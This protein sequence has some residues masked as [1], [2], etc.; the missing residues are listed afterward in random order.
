MKKSIA[1]G[2]KRGSVGILILKA[3]SSGDKYGYEILKEVEE[4]SG[5]EYFLKQPSLYSSL[6]RMAAN[7]LITSYWED[8]DIGG[9]R[10]YYNL[11]EAGKQKLENSNFQWP[12]SKGFVKDMFAD[13]TPTTP[14]VSEEPK[15]EIVAEKSSIDIVKEEVAKIEAEA[16][17]TVEEVNEIIEQPTISSK[18]LVLPTINPKQQDLFSM[19]PEPQPEPVV[20]TE[21]E[22]AEIDDDTPPFEIDEPKEEVKEAEEVVE[23]TKE[24]EVEVE[25][26]EKYTETPE[27]F[28]Q[29]PIFEEEQ[30]TFTPPAE[31]KEEEIKYIDS[32]AHKGEFNKLTK[33]LKKENSFLNKPNSYKPSFNYKTDT[34]LENSDSLYGS[35]ELKDELENAFS[36]F[37]FEGS[38]QSSKGF[39][40]LGLEENEPE[41]EETEELIN[42]NEP[43]ESAEA[44]TIETNEAQPEEDIDYKQIMG[45]LF[46]DDSVEE[47]TNYTP[48]ELPRINVSSNINVSLKPSGNKENKNTYTPP[49]FD[50]N[51]EEYEQRQPSYTK[52]EDSKLFNSPAPVI[53]RQAQTV[54]NHIKAPAPLDSDYS[55]S[56]LQDTYLEDVKVRVHKKETKNIKMTTNYVSINKLNSSVSLTMFILML[57]QIAV[58]Y[59]SLTNGGYLKEN[60]NYIFI[61]T[62]AFIFAP[63]FIRYL[64]Y[65]FNPNRKLELRYSLTNK[66]TT[67]LM[68]FLILLVLT[69]AINLFMGMTNLNQMDFIV[70]WL[71]PAVISANLLIAPIVKYL[72]LK[73]RAYYY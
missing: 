8:S 22:E 61:G 63:G 10:H 65:A 73:R 67:N 41:V 66:L 18:G 7:G 54:T 55:N 43:V 32:V 52:L 25:Q 71:L 40:N 64:I 29:M 6:K 45:D 1:T 9:R 4:K 37:N 39:D 34:N 48:Q 21:V 68:L 12:A 60:D 59:I 53:D 69:Y 2:T 26:K 17:E 57:I 27:T 3:L 20:E 51:P 36:G 62:L 72:L 47:E 50:T 13:Q 16:T 28:V 70:T 49:Q 23:E 38:E 35:Y 5:G 46:S 11:T 30:T 42:I 15:A 19:A 24:P 31:E 14:S 33:E 44:E 56:I 58:L